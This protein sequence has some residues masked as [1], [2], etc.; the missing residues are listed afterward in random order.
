MT[1]FEMGPAIVFCPADRP[2][3]YGKAMDRERMG[4]AAAAP[5]LVGASLWTAMAGH[6]CAR[7]RIVPSLTK[8]SVSYTS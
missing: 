5:S 6:R 3:R 8:V 2:E 7:G 1:P 4:F